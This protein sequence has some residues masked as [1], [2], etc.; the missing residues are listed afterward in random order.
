[1]KETKKQLIVYVTT[2]FVLT[3]AYMFGVIYPAYRKDPATYT[4]LASVCMAFPTVSMLLTR[5]FTKEGFTELLL[6]P[7][8]KGN[9][10]FY[11]LAWLGP[12]ILATLGAALYFGLFP[13]K[14][15]LN[16]GYFKS[17]MEASGVPYEAQTVPIGTLIALQ[18]I[19][20]ALLAGPLNLIFALG[21]EWGWR[22]Y[23]M[24]RLRKITTPGKALLLGGFIWGLWHAPLIAL[25]HNYGTD[26]PGWPWL[27][28]AA[29]CVL[30]MAM[31]TLLTWLTEKTGSAIPAAVGHG[32]INGIAAFGA[33]LTADGGDPFVGPM[34]T[35]IIGGL[36]M[37]V[38]A[39]IAARW[40]IRKENHKTEE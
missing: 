12:A 33:Y 20:G 22:G 21:E 7:R 17:L 25:G 27:G 38:L 13:R 37:L 32:A 34:P 1:M 40:M 2:V 24:P 31:G 9:G 19:Q 3:W 28:I 18:F 10:K 35:G 16:F 4:L 23:M 29:M 15:D 11:I 39:L 5:L 26:Y 14:L 36:P 30:C 6:R 8:F